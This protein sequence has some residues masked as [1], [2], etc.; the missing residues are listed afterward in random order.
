[1]GTSLLATIIEED[2]ASESRLDRMRNALAFLA[3]CKRM[4]I[5]SFLIHD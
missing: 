2:P 3:V 1:M 5:Y 4:S